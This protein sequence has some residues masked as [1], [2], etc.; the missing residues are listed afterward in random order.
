MLRWF[1]CPDGA[2][3]EIAQCLEQ[4]RMERRCARLP[5]LR[6]CQ[7]R[8]WTGVPSTTQLLNGTMMEYLKIVCDYGIAPKSR[9]YAMLGTLHHRTL[10]EYASVGEITE[11]RFRNDVNSGQCDILEPCE[12]GYV[13]GDYKTWGSFRVQRALGLVAEKIDD[14]SGA[15]YEKSGKWGKAGTPKQV[16]IWMPQPLVADLWEVE[17][18]LNS[19]R[20]LAESAGFPVV[21]MEIQVTVRDGATWLAHSRGVTEPLYLIPVDF[22]LDD[23]VRRYFG[24]KAIALNQALV[25]GWTEACS[26]QEC[27]NGRRCT[28][29]CDVAHLCTVRVEES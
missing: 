13:L 28:Q 19:Y 23:D 10:E 3:V 16:N 9:A 27:W 20:L 12:G 8:E 7:A 15:V 14:P 25:H 18:Q 29:Y 2:L 22:L 24:E 21:R 11:Q 1:F 26:A 6:A 5:Y 17:L 4:C